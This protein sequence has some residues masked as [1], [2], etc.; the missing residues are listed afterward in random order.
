MGFVQ[1]HVG[2]TVFTWDQENRVSGR[3]VAIVGQMCT[4]EL[5]DGTHLYRMMA[6]LSMVE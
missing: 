2:Q 1:F 3:I 5:G 6:V 4:L